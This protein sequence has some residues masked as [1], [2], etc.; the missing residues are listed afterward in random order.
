[1]DTREAKYLSR[2]SF[3]I[4]TKNLAMT[5]CVTLPETLTAF[6]STGHDVLTELSAR[7]LLQRSALQSGKSVYRLKESINLFSELRLRNSMCGVAYFATFQPQP[8]LCLIYKP[9]PYSEQ[10]KPVV[11]IEPPDNKIRSLTKNCWCKLFSSEQ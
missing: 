5:F 1:M 9:S 2:V 10:S 3:R 11:I 7:E 4:T 6:N 8:K